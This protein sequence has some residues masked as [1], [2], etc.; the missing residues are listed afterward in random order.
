MVRNGNWDRKESHRL[1]TR[2]LIPGQGVLN[3]PVERVK[4]RLRTI[5]QRI[6]SRVVLRIDHC[7]IDTAVEV[8]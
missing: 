8:G 5:P 2:Q 6:L 1:V 3:L 7:T 4:V